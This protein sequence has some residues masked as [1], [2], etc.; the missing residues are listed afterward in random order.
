MLQLWLVQAVAQHT[1][2]RCAQSC[3]AKEWTLWGS[4]QQQRRRR[5][6]P[7]LPLHLHQTQSLP[8]LIWLIRLSAE[9]LLLPACPHQVLRGRL[10]LQAN[11]RQAV[12]ACGPVLCG[13]S[14]MMCC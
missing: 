3:Q 7:P 14:L 2:R 12:L 10:L 9:Q 5:P 4:K 1:P 13:A 8:Q 11:W 6:R